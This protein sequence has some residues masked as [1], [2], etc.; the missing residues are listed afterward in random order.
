M[1]PKW[2]SFSTDMASVGVLASKAELRYLAFQFRALP[3]PLNLKVKWVLNGYFS[4]QHPL[5]VEYETQNWCEMVSKSK[6][7]S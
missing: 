4:L 6:P 3:T 7:C 5:L 2:W 1:W